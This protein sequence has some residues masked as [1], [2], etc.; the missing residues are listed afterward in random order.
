[1]SPSSKSTFWSKP[2]D[3]RKACQRFIGI[4]CAALLRH[5]EHGAAE[6]KEPKAQG[7]GGALH[8]V[9]CAHFKAHPIFSHLRFIAFSLRP[10]AYTLSVFFACLGET[11]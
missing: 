3:V 10:A 5:G 7:L 1:M 4:A 2:I 9:T 8:L 6:K 11:P